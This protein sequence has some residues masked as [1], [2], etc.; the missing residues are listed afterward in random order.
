MSLLWKAVIP[1]LRTSGLPVLTAR[2]GPDGADA[3]D[4]LSDWYDRAVAEGYTGSFLDF[5]NDYSSALGIS[6][7]EYAVSKAMRSSVIIYSRFTTKTYSPFVG[8]VTKTAYSAGA[9]VIIADDKSGGNA[10]IV[11]NYHVI[12]DS[13][14]VSEGG[15]A[16]Y[17]GVGLYGMNIQV[18]SS[19]AS[20]IGKQLFEGGI[21]RRIYG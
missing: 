2:T 7:S 8:Y 9:G 14:A 4:Y 18:S 6:G 11:T 21:R 13:S 10:Y 1:V 20:R 19:D 16:E 17:I 12:Y 5:V 3:G 15:I